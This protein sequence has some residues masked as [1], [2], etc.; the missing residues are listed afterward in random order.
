MKI[1]FMFERIYGGV[2]D[3]IVN[4]EQKLQLLTASIETQNPWSIVSRGYA[5]IEKRNK[6]VLSTC[7]VKSGDEIS[8]RLMDGEITSQVLKVEEVKK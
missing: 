2:Q 7:D 1:D 8:I 3:S 5:K 6:P 4:N